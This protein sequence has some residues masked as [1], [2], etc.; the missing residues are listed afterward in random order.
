TGPASVSGGVNPTGTVTFNLYNNPTATGPALFTDTEPLVGGVATS[1]GYVA[2]ATG[3]DYWVAT[4]NGDSNN[5]AV[6][7]GTALEPVTITSIT[8]AINTVPGGTVLLGSGVKLSDSA[9]LSGGFNPGGT[10]TFTLYDPTNA[11]V[12]TDVVTVSGNGSYNTSVGTN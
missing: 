4:Y 8:P 10:I 11:V 3:T 12:Y 6:T 2:T 9:V 5:N 7:S 1:V